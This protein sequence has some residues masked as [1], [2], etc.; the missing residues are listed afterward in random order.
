V[1][2]S[3]QEEIIGALWVIA[4]VLTLQYSEFYGHIMIGK[5]I[6]DNIIAIFLGVKE[7][8]AEEAKK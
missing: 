6:L 8:L 1:S 3:R 2:T 5:G 4:G 7:N